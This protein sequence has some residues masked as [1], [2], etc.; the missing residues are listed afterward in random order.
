MLWHF[1][2]LK[3]EELIFALLVSLFWVIVNLACPFKIPP[4]SAQVVLINTSYGFLFAIRKNTLLWKKTE[5]CQIENF[6]S[7]SQI[8]MWQFEFR[9]SSDYNSVMLLPVYWQWLRFPD[10]IVLK[11]LSRLLRK[12]RLR[13]RAKIGV[14]PRRVLNCLLKIPPKKLLKKLLVGAVHRRGTE[15]KSIDARQIDH[16]PLYQHINHTQRPMVPTHTRVCV[17][18]QITGVSK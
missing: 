10:S 5:T 6:E 1:W 18:S 12:V 11:D 17:W 15:T 2:D 4:D 8:W 9:F 7:L 14:F 16:P 13:G 3:F